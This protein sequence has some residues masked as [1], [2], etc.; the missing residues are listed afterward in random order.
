[1][2]VYFLKSISAFLRLKPAFLADDEIQKVLSDVKENLE[3]TENSGIMMA[4]VESFVSIA[5]WKPKLFEAHF[6]VS[7]GKRSC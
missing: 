1:L 6:Q 2:Q 3:K 5:G 4:L 7:E